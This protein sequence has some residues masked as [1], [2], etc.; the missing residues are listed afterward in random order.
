MDNKFVRALSLAIGLLYTGAYC[1]S[2]V[3]LLGISF[4]FGHEILEHH[5][6]SP[7]M[8]YSAVL[9]WASGVLCALVWPLC[10]FKALTGRW[11][12]VWPRVALLSL[13]GPWALLI[14]VPVTQ[15]VKRKQLRK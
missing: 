5:G 13:S 9:W 15:T 4:M 3:A 1:A 2:F 7:S 14:G 11:G 8:M 6:L 12:L 10:F